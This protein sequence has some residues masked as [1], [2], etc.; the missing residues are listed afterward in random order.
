MRRCS[1]RDSN[2]WLPGLLILAL[3]TCT[4]SDHPDGSPAGTGSVVPLGE[5]EYLVNGHELLLVEN[6][7]SSS[8]VWLVAGDRAGEGIGVLVDRDPDAEGAD[9][10]GVVYV[11]PGGTSM[12]VTLDAK[13]DPESALF[14]DGTRMEFSKVT[15]SGAHATVRG[16]DGGKLL[17]TEVEWDLSELRD[18]IDEHG[19]TVD[20][21]SLGAVS[22]P[23]PGRRPLAASG[24][25]RPH[26]AA[27]H[28]VLRVAGTLISVV[29]CAGSGLALLVPGGQITAPAAALACTSAAAGVVSTIASFVGPSALGT[30]TGVGSTL[31]SALSC[32]TA[33]APDC[34]TLLL[35][36]FD[37]RLP[38]C[39]V[40]AKHHHRLC[41]EGTIYW[42]NDC[43]VLQETAEHCKHGCSGDSCLPFEPTLDVSLGAEPRCAA[44]K[45][46][47]FFSA[48]AQGGD[49]DSYQYR[50]DFG[51]GDQSAGPD[52]MSHSYGKK[53]SYA[54]ELTVEDDAGHRG[55]AAARV[56]VGDCTGVGASIVS[57][58]CARPGA[59]LGLAAEVNGGDSE[60]LEYGWNLGD[61]TLAHGRS[62]T[63]RYLDAGD[64]V[65]TLIVR[66][67]DG[68]LARATRR[69]SVGD[70]GG[71]AGSDSAGAGGQAGSDSAGAGG[72]VGSD[73][74]GAGM[75][76][77]AEGQAGQA[78]MTAGSAGTA[79]DDGDWT[80]A[81]CDASGLMSLQAGA[82]V[83]RRDQYQEV[84]HCLAPATL[85]Y[86]GDDLNA[87]WAAYDD[88]SGKWKLYSGELLP[89]K[90]Y[91]IAQFW[92]SYV[93]SG[94]TE[95][96]PFSGGNP[97][98]LAAYFVRR[99]G[100]ASQWFEGCGWIY[101]YVTEH[102]ALPPGLGSVEIGGLNPCLGTRP[103]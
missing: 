38:D 51:D 81:A 23:L 63:H 21:S 11:A 36:V 58:A 66:D 55:W 94:E 90:D 13:G 75:G 28:G 79:G 74:A 30:W 14:D 31:G 39:T 93:P 8:N 59:P 17:A 97:T 3:T 65:A 72:R 87:Y 73:S 15:A 68:F 61:G 35:A 1:A 48:F 34:V 53:G 64:Y 12:T 9:V 101:D 95:F 45:E 42:V 43:D 88:A 10:S 98:A 50:W 18:R 99:T 69:V 84:D 20:L 54:V 60:S 32:G 96:E 71:Q 7:D 4:T 33:S 47:F 25:N 40:T 67:Q 44:A 46:N 86:S 102:N 103:E 52:A 5:G 85:T 2:R 6:D 92:Q 26:L 76:G 77:S 37:S 83:Y 22:G 56:Q 62:V 91:A 82:P 70:C 24:G 100:D 78:I 80:A 89:G 29:A 49:S 41:L 27:I 16:P 57:E 19:L